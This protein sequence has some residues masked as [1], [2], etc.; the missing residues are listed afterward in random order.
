MAANEMLTTPSLEAEQN[1]ES[2]TFTHEQLA[3]FAE[4][5]RNS[6]QRCILKAKDFRVNDPEVTTQ[7]AFE[8]ALRYWNSYTDNGYSREVW[9]RRIVSNLAL[10]EINKETVRN[11]IAKIEL[12]SG[13]SYYE[14]HVDTR[15]SET[16]DDIAMQQYLNHIA[17]VLKDH[18]KWHEMFKLTLAGYNYD[19]ISQKIGVPSGSIMSGIS[20][21]RKMLRSDPT[22]RTMLG[23]D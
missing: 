9:L 20:R 11:N 17:E 3:E 6:Y 1:P 15:A 18:P 5:Y 8:K 16:I 14:D 23:K 21:A 7:N 13:E 10:G 19:E 22:I 2:E 12:S 4:L